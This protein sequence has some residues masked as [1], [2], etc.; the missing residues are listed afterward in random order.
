MLEYVV[1]TRPFAEPQEIVSIIR[2]S[3]PSSASFCASSVVS[4]TN[5]SRAI[6]HSERFGVLSDWPA[7]FSTA[8]QWVLM[9]RDGMMSLLMGIHPRSPASVSVSEYGVSP[10]TPMG[11]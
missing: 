2:P 8:S 1:V 6:L 4:A 11:G 9:I 3:V 7:P 10:A 5:V